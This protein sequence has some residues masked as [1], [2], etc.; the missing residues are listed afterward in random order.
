M[1]RKVLYVCPF[2]EIGGVE[3]FIKQTHLYGDSTQFENHYLLFRS[4]PVSKF[5]LEHGARVTLLE[6]PPQL[7]I[8]K[9]HRMVNQRLREIIN[10]N[11]VHL[12]HS[13]GAKGALFSA[14]AAKQMHIPHVWF[15]YYPSGTLDR[16]AALSP[17]HGLVVT[18]HF[19]AQRQ[20][21]V[22][23]CVRWLIARK[24][25]IEK[26]LLG[27][28][29]KPLE[30]ARVNAERARVLA[31]LGIDDENNLCL[32]SMLGRIHPRKGIE[33]LLEALQELK[34][35]HPQLNFRALIFGSAN[36][37][38]K[39]KKKL[40]RWIDQH[41]LPAH[42]MGIS[43]NVGLSHSVCDMYVNSCVQPEAFS[44]SLIEAMAMGTPPVVP[45]SGALQEVIQNGENGLI[46]STGDSSS[47]ANRLRSL[48]QE[49]S[50]R[51]KL[52]I[53]AQET[54]SFRHDCAKTM[55]HL[56][57]FYQKIFEL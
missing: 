43:E 45:D 30:S 53:K 25:P 26:I 32:I 42:F 13:L 22:E 8:W 15:Q 35:R 7:F 33:V 39:Y 31:S 17:H 11:K 37:Q 28:D 40:Q 46:F 56:E 44:H 54:V 16:L 52:A 48:I 50:L 41:Q 47:L 49:K 1:K 10:K 6:T 51:E 14:T 29:L 20:R 36:G 38:E 9:D 3:T 23:K 24:L 5:L 34:Q 57:Q 18:S 55:E 12:V 2:T 27:T 4:G 19:A 21:E